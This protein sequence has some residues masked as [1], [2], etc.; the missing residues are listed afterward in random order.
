[1]SAL[2]LHPPLLTSL[3]NS[4]N[5]AISPHSEMKHGATDLCSRCIYAAKASRGE[6]CWNLGS[7]F[8][9]KPEEGSPSGS[10]DWG[11][12]YPQTLAV[13]LCAR[14]RMGRLTF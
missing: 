2:S 4:K 10:Q 9:S 6:A 13:G 1:M 7:G 8:F 5:L 12:D 14:G 3:P 11:P